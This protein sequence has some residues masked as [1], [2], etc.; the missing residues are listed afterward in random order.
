MLLPAP[1]A[2][3]LHSLPGIEC[4]SVS[5]ASQPRSPSAFHPTLEKQEGGGQWDFRTSPGPHILP[6]L[7][8]REARPENS[9]LRGGSGAPGKARHSS[10]GS[11]APPRDTSPESALSALLG[12]VVRCRGAETAQGA[13]WGR[14]VPVR[15]ALGRRLRWAGL[16]R[17]CFNKT[18]GH[19]SV[20]EAIFFRSEWEKGEADTAA[21]TASGAPESTVRGQLSTAHA[22]TAATTSVVTSMVRGAAPRAS[23]SSGRPPGRQPIAKR[24]A[25]ITNQWKLAS[26]HGSPAPVLLSRMLV[27]GACWT[28]ANGER[29]CCPRVPR[30]ARSGSQ[31][32]RRTLGD[33]AR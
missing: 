7:T 23:W 10:T 12:F 21:A 4:E 5:A 26:W 25:K 6:R 27:G 17:P 8:H 31:S 18:Q 16:D 28:A 33:T 30:A 13:G 19:V 15:A 29:G 2:Q 22:A 20:F 9:G 14:A 32:A 1:P 24:V 11:A 3:N